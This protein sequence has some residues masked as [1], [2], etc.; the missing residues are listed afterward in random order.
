MPLGVKDLI[1]AVAAG[2][3][4]FVSSCLCVRGDGPHGRGLFTTSDVKE[5]E[6]VLSIPLGCAVAP[7]AGL[8]LL[9]QIGMSFATV[10]VD[11]ESLMAIFIALSSASQCNVQSKVHRA[12]LDTLPTQQEAS[13]FLPALWDLSDKSDVFQRI[14]NVMKSAGHAVDGPETIA[15]AFKFIQEMQDDWKKEY[16]RIVAGIYACAHDFTL[17][18]FMYG[19][20]MVNSRNFYISSPMWVDGGQAFLLPLADMANHGPS[21]NFAP[22]SAQACH[23]DV[24]CLRWKHNLREGTVE[25]AV[26]RPISADSELL[27]SYSGIWQREVANGKRLPLLVLLW[28]SRACNGYIPRHAYV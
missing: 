1:Q 15:S 11:S 28:L 14:T 25:F 20:A 27:I 24:E 23:S 8:Q 6:L 26:S 7:Q 19:A 9:K 4:G 3:N 5:G 10:E 18:L 16:A 13:Q 2:P 12:Y 17:D 21:W 22:Y